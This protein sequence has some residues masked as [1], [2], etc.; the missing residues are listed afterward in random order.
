MDAETRLE[1]AGKRAEQPANQKGCNQDNRRM[2]DAGQGKI[3]P[4]HRGRYC[5]HY[6]LAFRPDVEQARLKSK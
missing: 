2:N 5:T 4:K 3:I 6:V 1:P